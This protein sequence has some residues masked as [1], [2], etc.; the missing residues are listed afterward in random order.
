MLQRRIKQNTKAGAGQQRKVEE[1]AA[2]LSGKQAHIPLEQQ[3]GPSQK[4]ACPGM[5][6]QLWFRAGITL[7]PGWPEAVLGRVCGH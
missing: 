5:S 6:S 7:L 1:V 2:R 4:S 3:Q